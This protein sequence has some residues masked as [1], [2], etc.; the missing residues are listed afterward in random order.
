MNATIEV[1]ITSE[2]INEFFVALADYAATRKG[3]KRQ[4]R[5]LAELV[6]DHKVIRVSMQADHATCIAR[7]D[8]PEY[9]I[10]AG[11]TFHLFMSGYSDING[12]SYAYIYNANGCACGAYQHLHNCKHVPLA[13]AAIVARYNARK[14]EQAGTLVLSPV[15][16]IREDDQATHVAEDVQMGR[17]PTRKD[18]DECSLSGN[19]GFSLLKPSGADAVVARIKNAPIAKR[20]QEDW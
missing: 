15:A 12:N 11:E 19:A 18:L 14:G 20:Q 13:N 6:V 8:M 7:E 17:F 1:A 4:F 2:T 5:E 10:A 3:A 9:G 16:T